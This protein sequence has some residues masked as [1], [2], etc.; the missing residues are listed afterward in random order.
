MT[1]PVHEVCYGSVAGCGVLV[2]VDLCGFIAVVGGA[3]LEYPDETQEE[4][5]YM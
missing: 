5:R 1:D 4:S 3:G 2:V